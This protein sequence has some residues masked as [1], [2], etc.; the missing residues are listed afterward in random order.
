MIVAASKGIDPPAAHQRKAGRMKKVLA[1]VVSIFWLAVIVGIP[2]LVLTGNAAQFLPTQLQEQL[3]QLAGPD[4]SETLGLAQTVP[5]QEVNEPIVA[6][7]TVTATPVM[8]PTPTPTQPPAAPT[9]T[10]EPPTPTA[11]PAPTP[12]NA[13]ESSVDNNI[14]L[15]VAVRG[16][17][18][19]RTGPGPE[20]DAVGFVDA[21]A[22]VLVSAQDETGQWFRLDNGQWIAVDALATIPP[23]PIFLPPAETTPEA[24]PETPVAEVPAAPTTPATPVVVTVNADANLRSGPG[25]TF[26]RVGGANF[27]TEVTVVGKFASDNWYLLDSG[28]W[29]FGELLASA[30]EVPLVNAD[31]TPVAG[32]APAAPAATAAPA[33]ATGSAT[34]TANTL[35]NLRAAPST[36]A[37]ITGSAQPGQALSIV[38]KNAAGDWLKL[39]TGS[40]IF[41]A[42]VDNAPADL[43]VVSADAAGADA[44]G[45]TTTPAASAP[46]SDAPATTP[47]AAATPAAEATP[48]AEP[49]ADPAATPEPAT[50]TAQSTAAVDANLRAGP[51]TTFDRVGSV[52]A[53]ASLTIVGRNEAGD[54][55]KLDSGAWIFAELVNN[56]PAEL[57]VVTQ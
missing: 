48:E 26:E 13:A 33:P 52:T 27:G 46:A 1:V 17:A 19:L 22:T 36:T 9:P 40:W 43:P 45:S 51:G 37:D 11:Q 2:A 21:G 12:E 30:P 47:D 6:V 14:A 8:E 18:D 15:P 41:A 44:A 38:G 49:T 54:W 55:F 57:P 16:Q 20:F 23:V 42:L 4:L 29:I 10:P 5:T 7:E 28:A 35:A 56:P 50:G 25:G 32:G 53:G 24:T 3:A 31:G 34:P 39:D